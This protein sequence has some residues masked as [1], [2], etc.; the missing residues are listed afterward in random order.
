VLLTAEPFL[1][2]SKNQFLIIIT[3]TISVFCYSDVKWTNLDWFHLMTVM[4]A[5]TVYV[6]DSNLVNI[7]STLALL[8][9]FFLY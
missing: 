7:L 2:S 5:A 9:I 6:H 3:R 8:I 1:Q 4:N